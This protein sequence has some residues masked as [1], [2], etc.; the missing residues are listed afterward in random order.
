MLGSRFVLLVSLLLVLS[1][2]GLSHARVINI[3]DDFETIQDGIDE[4]E[5]GDT[6]LV[7]P[8]TY[9]ENINFEGKAITVGS[10][11][12][13]TGDEAYVD[14]TVIDG[15]ENGTVVTFRNSE[16]RDAVLT[17]FTIQNGST[18]QPAGI[19]CEPGS[20]TITHCI[21]QN[22]TSSGSGGGIGIY[23]DSE[24]IISQCVIRNNTS[25][26]SGGG[27]MV[28]QSSNA[29]IVHC[30]ITQNRATA[31]S[32][33]GGG[34]AIR[35]C[36]PLIENCSIIDN[37]NEG[38][39]GMLILWGA[40]PRIVN[41]IFW[42]NPTAI[43]FNITGERNSVTISYSDIEG[44][45]DGISGDNGDINWGEG[46]IDEDPL[47]ADPDNGDFHL[48]EDSPCIDAGD[49]D[50]PEDP[51]G[52]RADMGAYYFHHR[53]EPEIRE[54]GHFDTEG[55]AH[56]VIVADNLAYI[57]ALGTGLYIVDVD[58]PENPNQIGLCEDASRIRGIYLLGNYVYAANEGDGLSVIDISDP[59]NPHEVGSIDT[60][61]HAHG[62]AVD[63]NYAF[64]ATEGTGLLVVDISD[65][66]NP[67]LVETIDTPGEA[68]NVRIIDEYAYVADAASGLR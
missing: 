54:V 9:V 67:I 34:I 6:V 28:N 65:P 46:N 62:V 51:D 27:V 19:D 22:N 16:S 1:F 37:E 55:E 58:D 66:E 38:A 15:D 63:G 53:N 35:Q 64:V 8:G 45:E 44:G 41:S 40:N 57:A 43:F 25:H 29:V 56:E 11:I 18:D 23:Q 14:S 5:D 49:P 68:K 60:D 17:G 36:A 31:E 3:P 32:G 10:L 20:P 47:F 61:G 21:I 4:A 42:D 59:D 50:S 33:L 30:L 7:Q 48:T 52:T 24:P 26:W 12:L 39:D 13:T 2:A